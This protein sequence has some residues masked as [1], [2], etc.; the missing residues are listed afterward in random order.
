MGW[1]DSGLVRQWVI[2]L[3]AYRFRLSVIYFPPPT[4]HPE[5][6]RRISVPA[7]SDTYAD[8]YQSAGRHQ[9]IR[10]QKAVFPKARGFRRLRRPGSRPRRGCAPG[11]LRFR[12][13]SGLVQKG[14]LYAAFGGYKIA[15]KPPPQPFE[16]SE[17][18][19][20]SEPGTRSGPM[21]A[22]PSE[23]SEPGRGAAII[24]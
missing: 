11:G 22:E 14:V 12:P 8:K 18:C 15:A 10:H 19:E 4:S 1:W 13:Q 2:G 5:R 3:S 9:T 17:P 21:G 20:P 7:V 23:P 6:Q 16:P 24:I